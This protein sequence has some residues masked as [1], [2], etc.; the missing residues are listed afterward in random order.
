MDWFVH[1]ST[2]EVAVKKVDHW[3]GPAN[4]SPWIQ[5]VWRSVLSHSRHDLLSFLTLPQ[6]ISLDSSV[7]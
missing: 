4:P 6:V 1:Q 3:I 2:V 5:Y 7:T